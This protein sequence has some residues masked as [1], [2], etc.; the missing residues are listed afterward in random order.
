MISKSK[1]DLKTKVIEA[2]SGLK[3]RNNEPC[4]AFQLSENPKDIRLG[5][6]E[7]SSQ[8]QTIPMMGHDEIADLVIESIKGALSDKSPASFKPECLT[9]LEEIEKNMRKMVDALQGVLKKLEDELMRALEVETRSKD[10]SFAEVFRVLDKEE[11][12]EKVDAAISSLAKYKSGEFILK[13]KLMDEITNSLY[14][15]EHD[16]THVFSKFKEDL[17]FKP[18]ESMLIS[19]SSPQASFCPPVSRFSTKPPEIFPE[20]LSFN[21]FCYGK[22]GIA[23]RFGME[24]QYG[25]YNKFLN[26]MIYDIDKKKQIRQMT[27]VKQPATQ[28]YNNSGLEFSPDGSKFLLTIIVEQSLLVY[29]SL[30]MTLV[31]KWQRHAEKIYIGRWIDNK[32]IV[33]SYGV[34]GELI[35]FD[36][37]SGSEVFQINPPEIASGLVLTFDLTPNKTHAVGNISRLLFK[38]DISRSNRVLDWFHNDHKGTIHSIA[39]SNNGK[40]V[41][42]GTQDE[43]L[44]ILLTR[45][46]DGAPFSRYNMNLKGDVDCLFWHPSD[47]WIVAKTK[48]EIL[49]LRSDIENGRILELMDE[50]KKQSWWA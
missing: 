15:S 16:I 20:T 42:S 13:T 2:L 23:K 21:S 19:L 28:C 7:I 35:V 24:H 18:K 31:R 45:L 22:G 9:L 43:V 34:F 6:R 44:E 32:R 41:A 1:H 10:R 4:L 33:A 29:S 11:L 46:E 26:V 49:L 50:M 48:E 27:A 17:E 47:K 12:G 39:V 38:V 3:T 5:S 14:Q 37:E 25:F 30:T 8:N 40:Y 36:V